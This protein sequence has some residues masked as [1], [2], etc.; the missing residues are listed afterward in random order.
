[1]RRGFRIGT[2]RGIPIVIDASWLVIAALVTWAFF[3]DLWAFDRDAS[4]PFTI[5]VAVA[6]AAVFFGSVLAHELSHSVVAISRDIPVHRIRLFVFGGVSEIE[7]DAAT[8]QDEFWMTAAGPLSSVLIGVLLFGVSL[9][10]PSGTIERMVVTL[11]VINVALGIFNLLPGFPLDGGRLLRSAVWRFTGDFHRATRVAVTG[12]RVMAVILAL[13]GFAVTLLAR[14]PFGLWYVFIGW[15]LWSAA[16]ASLVRMEAMDK[17]AGRTVAD[18]MAPAIRLVD[19]DLTL[20]AVAEEYDV[21][22]GDPPLPVLVDGRVR[23]L[24]GDAQLRRY[25]AADW[26]RYRVRTVM[27]PVGPEDVVPAD[28]PLEQVVPRLLRRERVVA[29]SDGRMVGTLTQDD[30]ERWIQVAQPLSVDDSGER[31]ASTA[32]VGHGDDQPDEPPPPGSA[33]V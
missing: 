21:Q 24:V 28:L 7:Q 16:G 2:I 30:V 11:A 25:P 26:G 31:D 1:M 15:F 33:A 4:L 8:P 27:D 12:G 23:G 32:G 22:P 14:D 18:L 5:V 13:I 10:L 6:G 9:V 19:P 17:L 29:V 20:A 3:A